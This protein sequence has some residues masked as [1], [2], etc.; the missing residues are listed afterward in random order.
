MISVIK[1]NGDRKAFDKN[2]ILKSLILATN[3]RDFNEDSVN[4]IVDELVSD[5]ENMGGSEIRSSEI[6]DMIMRRLVLLDKISYIRYASVYMNFSRVDDFTNAIS[7]LI[8]SE[9]E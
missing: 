9:R 3:K 8:D 4:V 2:K 5:I 6:G 1:S 7:E